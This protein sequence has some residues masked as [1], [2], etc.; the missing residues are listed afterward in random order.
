MNDFTGFHTLEDPPPVEKE[1]S[2]LAY[3]ENADVLNEMN[4]KYCVVVDGGRTRVMYFDHFSYPVKDGV[5]RTRDVPVF[6]TFDDLR[7]FYC[8][9]FVAVTKERKKGRNKHTH[10]SAIGGSITASGGSMTG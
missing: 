7:N 4:K 1:L 5:F 2:N 6:L 8:N 9:R 3:L 10:H